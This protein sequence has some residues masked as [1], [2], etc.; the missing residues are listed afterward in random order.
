MRPGHLI[1]AL[2]TALFAVTACSAGSDGPDPISGQWH[3]TIE[4]P[5]S[6]LEIGVHFTGSDSATIDIPVQGLNGVELGEV[7]TDPA[8]VG[9][10]LPDIPGDPT[11]KGAL[12][13]A[14]GRIGGE[15][16]QMG[17]SFPLTLEEGPT[18]PLARP[19][20]PQPPFPYRAEDVSYTN[21]DLDIAGTLT[22]PEGE[23]PF[24]AVVL[25]TGSGAQTR[26]E[27][28]FGHKPFLLIAD[29]LTRAG[30]AVLRTDDRG[31]GGT[32]GD[33]NT[34]SYDDLASDVEAGIDFLRGRA[35][36]DPARIGLFGHS[37]GGYLAPLV[38]ARPDSGVAFAVLMAG[39]SVDGGAVLIEQSRLI[40]AA[41]GTPP[42]Q[43][44]AQVAQTTE[45]VGLLR[46]GD[47]DGA[48]AVYERSLADLPEE[49]R[50]SAA[51]AGSPIT[52][53]YASFV[54][55]DPAPALSALRIP[56][57]AF[58]GGKDLQVPAAQNEQPARDLLTGTDATVHV[59]PEANHLMQ[60]ANTGNLDEYATIETTV[61]PQVLA[62]VTD[63]LA[64]RVPP[65]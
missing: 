18:A 6:P 20:E 11:F 24:P 46:A 45:M 26:D 21:G 40:L 29:T 4:V 30:Y 56:V 44:D 49:A 5:G 47:L 15:F 1:L 38:A 23:G 35:D 41:S 36:I 50:E 57:L 53:Y 59:F 22:L 9:F 42:E 54:N 65:K 27:E 32:G 48:R 12:D 51:Q 8:D 63:W 17:Q 3:G 28:L 37:E 19:Q 7:R 58:F 62:F 13:E 16:T 31:V 60:P 10:V 34:S 2:V 14:T 43:I 33:L 39:P 55:Y 61:D 25:I 52:P 64:G